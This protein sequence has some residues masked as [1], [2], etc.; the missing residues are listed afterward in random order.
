MLQFTK[1]FIEAQNIMRRLVVDETTLFGPKV[2][3]FGLLKLQPLKSSEIVQ[4]LARGAIRLSVLTGRCKLFRWDPW[5]I[6]KSICNSGTTQMAIGGRIT[7]VNCEQSQFLISSIVLQAKQCVG[8]GSS[9]C[10][11]C[12]HYSNTALWFLRKI[13]SGQNWQK[14]P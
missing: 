9:T 13:F 10:T 8:Q 14:S 2:K 3:L 4:C 6:V 11:N 5:W 1:Q 7:L 12:W